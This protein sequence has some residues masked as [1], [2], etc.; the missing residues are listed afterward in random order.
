MGFLTTRNAPQ[1]ILIPVNTAHAVVP[2][3]LVSV[4]VSLA[5]ERHA[6]IVLL[7]FTDVPLGERIDV[8]IDGLDERLQEFLAQA[9]AIADQYGVGVRPAHLRTRDPATSILAE[10]TRRGTHAILVGAGGLHETTYRRVTDDPTVQRIAAEAGQ[11]VMIVQSS[12]EA[13]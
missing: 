10:A 12:A 9:R 3:E 11:R 6:S 8:P 13:A 5:S 2:A 1:S 4:A 7:A